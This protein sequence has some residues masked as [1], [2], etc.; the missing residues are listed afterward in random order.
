M[1]V[2]YCLCVASAC[3]ATLIIA[4]GV[5]LPL[6]YRDAVQGYEPVTKMRQDVK[7]STTGVNP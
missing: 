4:V 6:L 3:A 2:F 7:P 1:K 5:T